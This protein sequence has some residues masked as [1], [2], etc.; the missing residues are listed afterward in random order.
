[1]L[2]PFVLFAL[3]AA[4]TTWFIMRSPG[5]FAGQADVL[6]DG[7]PH[8]VSV[9]TGERLM[10]YAKQGT[11][12]PTCVVVD[13]AN[14]TTVD[15]SSVSGS[16]TRSFGSTTWVGIA[17]FDPGSGELEVT[18]QPAGGNDSAVVEI[19]TP[20]A[21]LLGGVFGGIGI[22][23]AIGLVGFIWLIVLFVKLVTGAPRR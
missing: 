11:S 8:L 7:A 4:A 14:S 1:M 22:G 12:A 16:Q 21:T 10:L 13:T 9:D 5:S 2:G 23:L 6:A 18:C 3:A 17:E 20:V 19:A 15:L